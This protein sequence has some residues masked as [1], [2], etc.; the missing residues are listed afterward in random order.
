M[1]VKWTE[2]DALDVL[3]RF[4]ATVDRGTKGE[5]ARIQLL[6]QEVTDKVVAYV[7]GFANLVSLNLIY[8]NVTDAGLAYL[9]RQKTMRF[10]DLGACLKVTDEG[11]KHLATMAHLEVLRLWDTKITDA[12]LAHLKS[13][14]RLRELYLSGTKIDGSG[15]ASLRSAPLEGLDLR[16]TG[17]SD[18]SLKPLAKFKTLKWLDLSVNDITIDGVNQL[19]G[20]KNLERLQLGHTRVTALGVVDLK[21]ALPNCTIG[22]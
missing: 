16:A 20:L 15:F 12:G 21:R 22:R 4:D 7:A 17:L 18:G 11:I 10:L 2:E 3:R 8:A 5:V 1:A 14:T 9:A 13:C 19:A 6:G